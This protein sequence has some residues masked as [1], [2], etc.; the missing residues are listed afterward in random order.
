[1][2]NPVAKLLI[3]TEQ[4][5]HDCSAELCRVTPKLGT[6]AQFVIENQPRGDTY[7]ASVYGERLSGSDK[8][9]SK[10]IL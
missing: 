10:V 9:T 8:Y 2:I 5:R 1:M 6:R 4:S 7:R 3:S